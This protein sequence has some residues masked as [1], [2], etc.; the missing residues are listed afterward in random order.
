ML[1]KRDRKAA[2]I[3]AAAHGLYFIKA[4]YPEQYALPEVSYSPVLQDI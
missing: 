2:G 4:H 3:T 1:E